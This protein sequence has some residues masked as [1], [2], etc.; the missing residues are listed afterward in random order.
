MAVAGRGIPTLLYVPDIE[1]GLA[2]K[3][4]ARFATCIGLTAENSRSY[5][6]FNPRC[7]VTGYP[8]RP[9]L[10]AWEPQ[11]GRTHLNLLADQPVLFVFGG[12]KGARSLNRAV[13]PILPQLLEKV[14]VLHISGKLDWPEVEAAWKRLPS[15]IASRYHP[16]PYLHEEMG[17]AL[18]SANLVVSRAGASILGEFPLYGLPAILVPYPFAWRYQHVNADYLVRHGGAV[19]IRDEQLNTALLPGIQSLFDEPTRLESMSRAMRAL[20]HP[21]AANKLAGLVKE[22]ASGSNSTGRGA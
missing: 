7:V 4:L 19:V 16:Y 2:L 14:Q 22:L 9:G 20:A 1:P 5:F 21:Q 18:A 15:E 6:K 8:T 12:S 17:A 11:T 13:L 3:V 10:Q